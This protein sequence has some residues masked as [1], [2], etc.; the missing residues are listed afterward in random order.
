MKSTNPTL[1]PITFFKISPGSTLQNGA[2]LA[3][4]AL[5]PYTALI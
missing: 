1:K 2:L 3:Q 4:L 5:I